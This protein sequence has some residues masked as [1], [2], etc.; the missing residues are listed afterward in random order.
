M[1]SRLPRPGDRVRM[2]D[3]PNTTNWTRI[4]VARTGRIT[5]LKSYQFTRE[6][7]PRLLVILDY[8]EPRKWDNKTSN[9]IHAN[10]GQIEIISE[11][12]AAF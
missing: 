8:E 7:G 11:D 6:P 10:L 2:I 5:A 3:G 9:G 12:E 1:L 4:D